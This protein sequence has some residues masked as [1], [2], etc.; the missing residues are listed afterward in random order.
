MFR[1]GCSCYSITL[2]FGSI[3]SVHKGHK[4]TYTTRGNTHVIVCSR[5]YKFC[6]FPSLCRVCV[7]WTEL[8]SL[9]SH[10]KALTFNVTTFRDK[11]FKRL[12]KLNGVIILGS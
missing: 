12:L 2:D 6:P 7:L 1:L 4:D 3:P 11:A 5:A 8:C 10:V 9:N